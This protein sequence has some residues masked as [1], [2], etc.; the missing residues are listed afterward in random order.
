[1]QYIYVYYYRFLF[2]IFILLTILQS[3]LMYHRNKR[4]GCAKSTMF[5]IGGVSALKQ[6]AFFEF[7][8]WQALERLQVTPPFDFA[9]MAAA[10]TTATANAAAT[11][12]GNS[13]TNKATT[14]TT[15]GGNKNNKNTSCT[16]TMSSTPVKTNTNND[17]SN[18][19][20]FFDTEFTNQTLSLSMLEDTVFSN[21]ATPI[22]SGTTS[23]D[24][25]EFFP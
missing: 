2:Q 22:R 10:R 9:A 23:R 17:N 5:S 16:T 12:N 11:A 6:H 14:T 3:S 4:L 24:E 15:T 19:L 8:D 7:T 18:E 25:G 13:T 1:M 20:F 21:S